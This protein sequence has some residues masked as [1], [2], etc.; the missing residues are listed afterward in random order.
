MT[1]WPCVLKE[2]SP[3]ALDSEGLES[4]IWEPSCKE[5]AVSVD[6]SC[7]AGPNGQGQKPMSWEASGSWVTWPT[8]ESSSF[9]MGGPSSLAKSS[10]VVPDTG[11]V[12]PRPF[13]PLEG[14][15]RTQMFGP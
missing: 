14:T 12:P 11:C 7:C 5:Y 9:Q 4:G 1:T 3:L 8:P 15:E 2:R 10:R 6:M 13:W